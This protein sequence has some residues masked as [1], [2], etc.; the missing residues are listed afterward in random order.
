MSPWLEKPPAASIPNAPGSYQFKDSAGRVIYVG[1]ARS[2]RSRIG[3]YFADPKSL[4]PKTYQ[5]MSEAASIEWIRVGT[6]PEAVLLEYSLIKEHR[7]RFNIQLRDDKSYPFLALTISDE[8]PRPVVTRGHRKRGVRYFGPYASAGS[9]RDTLDMLVKSFPLRT[10]SDSKMERHRKLGR[11]CLLYHIDRCAGPCIGAISKDDYSHM[12]DQTIEF[13]EGKSNAVL[14]RLNS[15]ME[16]ASELLEFEKAARIRDRINS[17]LRALETQQMIVEAAEDFDALGIAEN[18]IEACIQVFHVRKGRV[19]GRWGF[20]LDKMNSSD[21]DELISRSLNVLYEETQMRIPREILLPNLPDDPEL[22]ESWLSVKRGSK[23]SLRVPKRGEKRRLMEI[24]S[25]NAEGE[26]ARAWMRHGMDF[27]ARSEALAGLRDALGL[28]E[29]PLRIECYDMSH[30]QG[31]DYVGSMVV[32]EDGLPKKRDYRHFRVD[33]VGGNDD[34]SAMREV[35]TRRIARLVED[36]SERERSG[37]MAMTTSFSYP[38]GLLLVDGGKGQLKVAQQVL[39]SFGLEH[40]IPVAALAKRLEEVF[41][42]GRDAPIVLDR[43]SPSLVML[44]RIR[45][46]A[47]RFAITYHRSLRNKRMVIGVLDGVPGLGP[48]RRKRL[49]EEFGGMKRVISA[50]REDFLAVTWLPD[51]VADLIYSKIHES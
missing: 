30:L 8:W 36:R 40:S 41:V 47:H 50:Q 26:L 24:V 21:N 2:L 23:V 25:L 1:K 38:P 12:V 15:E 27:R 22:Y 34:Y 14:D 43:R 42:P 18:E 6:D 20:E 29:A 16:S 44:Q 35:L 32:L 10:C 33:S 19:V 5:M 9:I 13:L 3:S 51:K 46:E 4:T 39:T 7:P 49:I 11:P 48:V 17:A 45:D 28:P 31:T 37:S